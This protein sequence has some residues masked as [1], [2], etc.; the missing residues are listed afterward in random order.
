MPR[1]RRALTAS[2]V[3][4]LLL[5]S[6]CGSGDDSTPAACLRPQAVYLT[7][8]S[9]APEDV[10]L[11]DDTSISSCLVENQAAGELTRVGLVLVRTTTTLNE[12]ARRSPDGLAPVQ[13][14]YLLGAVEK[15][16]EDTSGIHTALVRRIEAA[17]TFS[18]GGKPLPGAFDAAYQRGMEAGRESG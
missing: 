15:G 17:A 14:G 4:L 8:L 11:A 10:R 2:I 9:A 12:R 16:A 7:A 1:V 5:I 13:L 6:G 18:P 3:A